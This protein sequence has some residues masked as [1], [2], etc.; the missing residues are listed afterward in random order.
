MRVRAGGCARDVRGC[1]QVPARSGGSR[2][3]GMFLGVGPR[4]AGRCAHL[5]RGGLVGGFST[6]GAPSEGANTADMAPSVDLGSGPV[7]A[8]RGTRP[9]HTDALC[10]AVLGCTPR[11]GLRNGSASTSIPASGR[12]NY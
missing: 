6:V 10:R 12:R 9:D 5:H 11:P 8:R 1:A 7:R 2:I 3:L 4:R